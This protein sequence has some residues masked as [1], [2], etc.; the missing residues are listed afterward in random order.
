MTR[1][2]ICGI[3]READTEYLNELCPDFTGFVFAKSSRRYVTPERAL[4]LSRLLRKEIIPVGVFVDSALDEIAEICRS[5]AIRAIQLHGNE[6]NGFISQL[7][8]LTDLPIIQA[9]KV[10]GAED[11]KRADASTADHVLL[12]SGEGSG[13]RFDWS[14]ING[15]MRPYFLAGGLNSENVSAA[16]KAMHPFAVDVSSSVESDGFKDK[17]K[18]KEFIASV[19]KADERKD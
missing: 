13:Q 18:I 2:K 11:I 17:S 9:F 12:D 5:G 4:E 14:V 8:S 19:R 16:V 10:R 1:I 6:D 7:R 15:I 3:S